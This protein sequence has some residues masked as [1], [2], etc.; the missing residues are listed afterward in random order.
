M[1]DP[2]KLDSLSKF[3]T[4]F[5][6]RLAYQSVFFSAGNRKI[7]RIKFRSR[8]AR[9]FHGDFRQK[10]LLYLSSYEQNKFASLFRYQLLLGCIL[11]DMKTCIKFSV[12]GRSNQEEQRVFIYTNGLR[13]IICRELSN[14]ILT[15]NRRTLNKGN[16]I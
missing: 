15:M 4:V 14:P 11:F 16:L 6:S 13:D 9:K 2:L 10:R 12:L 1:I 7:E 3:P 8:L 5:R